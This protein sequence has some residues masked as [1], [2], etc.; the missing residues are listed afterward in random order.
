MISADPFV[1]VKTESGAIIKT[2]LIGA[3]NFDNIATALCLGKI[4]EVPEDKAI[5]AIENYVPE[6][7]RSQILK[8]GQQHNHSR[9]LQCQPIID[10]K[11][12]GESCQH[13]HWPQGGDPRR[14]V[15][16]WR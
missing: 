6:N 4:F 1:E 13:E 15:R 14:H 10:G 9:C 5:K 3:Y 8:K 11:G 7:N 2:E 12:T 16:T